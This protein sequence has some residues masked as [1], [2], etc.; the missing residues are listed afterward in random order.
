MW[1]DGW[2]F[3]L[4]SPLAW[5]GHYAVHFFIFLNQLRINPSLWFCGAMAVINPP[6][7]RSAMAVINPPGCRSAMAAINPPGSRSAMVYG[8]SWRP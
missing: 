3:A 5:I 7:C 6:G 8:S 4:M 2:C 1:F